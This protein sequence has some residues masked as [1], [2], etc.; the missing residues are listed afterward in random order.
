M[1]E[2]CIMLFTY[3]SFFLFCQNEKGLL[4]FVSERIK[5]VYRIN[6]TRYNFQKN[7]LPLKH[8]KPQFIIRPHAFEVKFISKYQL[9]FHWKS[10]ENISSFKL[11]LHWKQVKR[12]L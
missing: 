11:Y 7:K 8:L 1:Q 10:F 4:N 12:N 6:N 3:Y 9:L 5:L 2:G